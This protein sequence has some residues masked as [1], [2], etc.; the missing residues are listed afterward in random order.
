MTIDVEPTAAVIDDMAKNLE[1]YAAQLRH[2]SKLMREKRDITLSAEAALTV[3]NIMQ[4]MRLDLL[5]QR[6]LRAAGLK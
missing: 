3:G 1:H 5:V 4:N 2:L 6:P